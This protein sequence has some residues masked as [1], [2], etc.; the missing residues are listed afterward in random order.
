[1]SD[2]LWVKGPA[3]ECSHI[4]VY[5][6]VFCVDVVKFSVGRVTLSKVSIFV[7]E[8]VVDETLMCRVVKLGNGNILGICI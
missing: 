6:C 3:N 4:C 8:T 7:T 5:M 2:T 1:M